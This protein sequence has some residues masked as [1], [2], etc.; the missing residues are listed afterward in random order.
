MPA[1]VFDSIAD[2]L[3]ENALRKHPLREHLT[4]ATPV[5]VTYV[6]AKAE[7][8]VADTG[9]AIPTGLA[10]KLFTAPVTSQ[11]GLGVGLY[12]AAKHAAQAGFALT[13]ADNR[14][15]CVSFRLARKLHNIQ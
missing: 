6:P 1:E 4:A 13:L 10:A 7:L 9:D 12:H 14:Q 2:N 8:Q 11:S 5:A 15:G 3:I